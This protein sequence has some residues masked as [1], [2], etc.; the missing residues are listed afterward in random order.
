MLHV[1][2]PSPDT[3]LEKDVPSRVNII[4]FMQHL[5]YINISE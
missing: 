1:L 2:V 5:Q 4:I 3:T